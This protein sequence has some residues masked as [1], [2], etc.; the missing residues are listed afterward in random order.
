MRVAPEVLF[1]KGSAN[2]TLKEHKNG[3]R[4]KFRF[5]SRLYAGKVLAPG[6]SIASNGNRLVSFENKSVSLKYFDFF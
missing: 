1:F 4:N 2:K 6:I 3:P 5:S